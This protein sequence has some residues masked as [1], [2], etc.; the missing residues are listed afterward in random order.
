[1][2]ADALGVTKAA[3]YH[4][5]KSKDS[6]VL[7]VAEVGMAALQ[8]ALLAAEAEPSRCRAVPSS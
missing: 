5:F 7:A 8:E 4:Q 1:M 3:V 6:L 2:V